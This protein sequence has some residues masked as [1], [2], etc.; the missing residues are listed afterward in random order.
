M[1]FFW[2]YKLKEFIHPE[3]IDID[4]YEY[5]KDKLTKNALFKIPSMYPFWPNYKYWIFAILPFVISLF[6]IIAW[7]TFFTIDQK[8]TIYNIV[9]FIT[10]TSFIPVL[11]FYRK[12]ASYAH[13]LD[14]EKNYF[15]EISI[16]I[17]DSSDY[18]DFV[19]KFY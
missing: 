17:L 3:K 11:L 1:F 8:S 13:Y 18:H 14:Q 4:H 5:L 9:L 15:K 6:F 19:R 10:L 16:A 2:P 12:L 7:S